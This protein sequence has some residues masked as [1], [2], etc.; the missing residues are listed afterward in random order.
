MA[1]PAQHQNIHSINPDV[2]PLP[3]WNDVRLPSDG[4]VKANAAFRYTGGA[5]ISQGVET[6]LNHDALFWR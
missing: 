5:Q 6:L 4:S 2:P 1:E 3:R